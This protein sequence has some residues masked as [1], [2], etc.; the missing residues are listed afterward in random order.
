MSDLGVLQDYLPGEICGEELRGCPKERVLKPYSGKLNCGRDGLKD[1]LRVLIA[2]QKERDISSLVEKMKIT[3]GVKR[4]E[5]Q[6]CDRER[7]K[8]KRDSELLSSVDVGVRLGLLECGS[9]EHRIRPGQRASG[10]GVGKIE[11]NQPALVYAACHRD[12]GDAPDVLT[13]MFLIFDVPYLALIDIGSTHSYIA[14]SISKNLGLSME[15]TTSRVTVLSPL[16][17]SVRVSKLY[18]DIPLRV[19]GT[20]FLA[21]LMELSF[22]EFDIILG[23]NCLVKHQVSLD[24]ATERVILRNEEDSEVVMVGEHQNYLSNVISALVAKKLVRKGCEE[25]LAYVSVFDSGDTTVKD[26]RAVK[27]FLDVFPEKL[28]GLPSNCEVEF[29]IELLPGTA[30]VSIAPY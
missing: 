14:Y 10:R 6:N 19:Q 15:S 22:G 24:Y 4:T 25:F 28:P 1:N 9:L 11:V 12:E 20:V 27:D 18:R 29:G 8:N 26:I 13:G 16:G 3:E 23:I 17:Q 5:C 2:P 7:S 30:L 21:N